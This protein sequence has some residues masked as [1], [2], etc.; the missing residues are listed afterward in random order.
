M[1]EGYIELAERLNA[2]MPGSGPK[3]TLLL[4]TGA[5][6]T[7]NAVK[8]ARHATAERPESSPSP[9]AITAARCSR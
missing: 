6:A 3:K 1:Y 5:E 7:E 4:S 2:L 9:T 8:I